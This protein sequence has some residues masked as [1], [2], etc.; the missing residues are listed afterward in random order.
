MRW[1]GHSPVFLFL[2]I[3]ALLEVCGDALLRKALLE[4]AGA[5]RIA[6]FAAGAAVLSG[7][8]TVLN[9]APLEFGQLVGLYIAILFVM[10]QII[11]FAFFRILPTLADPGGR[12]VDRGGRLDRLFLEDRM[13]VDDKLVA[14]ANRLAD[15]C[16]AVIRP[17]FRQRIEVVHKP[18]RARASIRSP[19][20]TRAPNAPFAPSSNA[21][22]PTTASWAR[23]MA[24]SRARSGLRWVLDPVDGTRAFITGRHEWGSLIAL[25]ENEVP[26]LGILDQPVLGERFIGV[27]GRSVLHA[28]RQAHAAESARMRRHQRRHPLRHRSRTP[29]SRPDEQ[30]ALSPRVKARRA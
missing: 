11:N 14:F 6:L 19:R 30:A 15:A 28:G 5:A 8:G 3:A 22:A 26:V 23:N 16:G 2:L 7:Y 9:L 12:C 4:S 25:E 24:R 18:G 29:I 27:N 21:S 20:P 10:W 17:Y 1:L 13:T